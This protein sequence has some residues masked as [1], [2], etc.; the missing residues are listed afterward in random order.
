[1]NIFTLLEKILWF[2]FVSYVDD[3]ENGGG[4]DWDNQDGSENWAWNWA[5]WED[6]ENKNPW[7]NGGS[8]NKDTPEKQFKRWQISKAKKEAAQKIVD[9]KAPEN[10]AEFKKEDLIKDDDF[11]NL[12]N[13]MVQDKLNTLWVDQ[14]SKLNDI[15]SRL[16]KDDFFNQFKEAGKTYSEY[17]MSV[18]PQAWWEILADIEENWFT[19]QQL[20]LLQNADYIMWKFKGLPKSPTSTDGWQ[21]PKINTSN[22]SMMDRLKIIKEK[23]LG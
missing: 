1:M 6:G 14:N 23:H 10:K 22:M 20:I 3:N 5:D 19:P 4:S 12:L 21:K 9:G 8:E 7:D 13:D 2:S 16:E 17:W 15:E 11:Q 18:D